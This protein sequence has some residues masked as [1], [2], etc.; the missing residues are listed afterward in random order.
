MVN[1]HPSKS[2]NFLRISYWYWFGLNRSSSVAGFADGM[3]REPLGLLNEMFTISA[4]LSLEEQTTPLEVYN[5]TYFNLLG[6]EIKT[7][8]QGLY[9]KVMQTNKGQVAE[10]VYLR[11]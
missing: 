11:D 9:I 5:T 3:M 7:L 4:A 6:K 2:L 10:K 1:N 8:D